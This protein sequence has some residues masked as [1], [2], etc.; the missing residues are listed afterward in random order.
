MNENNILI[1]DEYVFYGDFDYESSYEITKQ[2]LNM[3][4]RPSAIFVTSNMMILGTIKALYEKNINIP[5]DMAIIGFDKL[6]LVNI[7]GM[8]ISSVNGPTIEMGKAGM[9]MLMDKLNNVSQNDEIK[10]R[11]IVPQLVLKGSEKFM[12]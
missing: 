7:L 1:E 5:K 6:D 2:I 3:K 9:K 8:N 11:I 4:D 12:P 10:R